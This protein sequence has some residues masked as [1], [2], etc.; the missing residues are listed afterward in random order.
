MQRL[1]HNLD[2]LLPTFTS[3]RAPSFLSRGKSSFKIDKCGSQS[4]KI[5]R[6]SLRFHFTE[7]GMMR[8]TKDTKMNSRLQNPHQA[9]KEHLEQKL[10]EAF[11]FLQGE[12]CYIFLADALFGIRLC[13]F[14]STPFYYAFCLKSDL[15]LLI[16]TFKILKDF[17][18]IKKVK[19]E[20]VV[21]PN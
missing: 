15:C 20:K 2:F 10:V 6:D 3:F 11:C 9:G 12:S 21:I 13:V 7:K 1:I 16:C 8:E 17:G 5:S 14:A 4:I 18:K 19:V